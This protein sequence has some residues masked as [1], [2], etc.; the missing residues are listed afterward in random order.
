MERNESYYSKGTDEN[1]VFGMLQSIRSNESI[2][3]KDYKI[4]RRQNHFNKMVYI[5]ENKLQR[6]K[7]NM[8]TYKVELNKEFVNANKFL[9]KNSEELREIKKYLDMLL[10]DE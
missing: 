7:M 6:Y 8:K 4:K 10:E 5:F 3:Q 1:A 9:S 2:L